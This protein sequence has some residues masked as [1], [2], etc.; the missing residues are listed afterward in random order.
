MN[1]VKPSDINA[2]VAPALREALERAVGSAYVLT[3]QE[4]TASASSATFS[5]TQ[6]IS[7][8]VRPGSRSELQ[9]VLAA[10]RRFAVPV[11]PVSSGRNW[12]YGSRVPVS[13]GCILI[14]LSRMNR[15]LDFNERLGW[16]TLEPGVTQQQLFDF[17]SS[18]K[19]RLWIDA[20]GSS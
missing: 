20:T 14:E 13:D 3:A 10:A 2:P 4:V 1:S 6:R 17:L 7:A 9:E 12:G 5:T 8:L 18:Q 16:V 11:Y 19:S 15:I